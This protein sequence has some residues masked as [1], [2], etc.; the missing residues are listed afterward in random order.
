MFAIVVEINITYETNA[1][2]VG[3]EWECGKWEKYFH[4]SKLIQ[5]TKSE[6]THAMQLTFPKCLSDTSC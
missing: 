2:G 6:N 5:A 4:P 1:I 3:Y